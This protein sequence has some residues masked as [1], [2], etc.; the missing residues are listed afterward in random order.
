MRIVVLDGYT[1]NPG[2]NPWDAIAAQG[3]FVVYD[4]TPENLVVERAKGA[5][6]VFVNKVRLPTEV[7]AALPD[8]KYIGVLATGYDVVDVQAAAARN[9]PVSN[10]PGYGT[11][12]VAE[13]VF[14]MLLAL[15]RCVEMHAR[16]VSEG[17]WSRSPDFCYWDSPQVGLCGKVM[18]IVG[19]G[20]IGG[21]VAKIASAFGMEVLGY[22]RSRRAMPDVS[23]FAWAESVEEVFEKSDC[24]SVH[25]PLTPETRHFINEQ[26]LSRMKKTAFLINTGRGPLIDEAALADALKNG[27]LAGAALDVLSV[28]PPKD[29]DPLLS[30][31]N[32]L[33]TPHIA[34]ATLEARQK[35][36]RIAARNLSTWVQ[37]TAQNIV[38]R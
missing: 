29:D 11:E 22:S 12:A 28:E 15:C 31:P 26:L 23:P 19:L 16:G 2:D 20:A 1:V 27:V 36:V 25:F 21:R 7:I 38:N 35:L 13:Q 14:A 6:A 8:L 5:D 3:D 18:G 4:R 30:L 33:V 37:G 17:R 9:V 34:W 24:I 32:C 10:I